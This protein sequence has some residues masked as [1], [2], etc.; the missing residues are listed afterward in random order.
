MADYRHAWAVAGGW[1]LDLFL[2]RESRPHKDVDVAIWRRD[3][4][5][6]QHQLRGF[7][8]CKVVNG[9]L[10]EWSRG[11]WLD[12]PVHE[13]HASR[14]GMAFEI[15]LNECDDAQ[16]IFRRNQRIRRDLP[17]ALLTSGT[18]PFLAPEV[19]LLYKS[20]DPSPTNEQ[21]FANV[22]PRLS[23]EQTLWLSRALATC[24]ESH[25]WLRVLASATSS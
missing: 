15:L 4:R 7:A 17:A 12:L 21:D 5:A 16:W 24:D 8:L 2:G 10:V 14:V 3:Q 9:N 13:I 25:P 1:A 18:V 20:N 6:L 23:L 11:D 22:A 19:V